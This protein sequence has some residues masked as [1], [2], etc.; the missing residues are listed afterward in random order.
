MFPTGPDWAA[1][2]AMPA[3]VLKV[4]NSLENGGLP[5]ERLVEL[6]GEIG[7]DIGFF[8]YG[9]ACRCTGRGRECGASAGLA[10]MGAPACSA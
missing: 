2:A 7:S 10:G 1:A 4:L 6:A 5:P 3:C 8:I 9:T